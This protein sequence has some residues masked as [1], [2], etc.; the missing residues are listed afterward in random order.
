V[1]IEDNFGHIQHETVTFTIEDAD[2]T[3]IWLEPAEDAFV[4]REF[5]MN[6]VTS[7][8]E[9][10]KELDLNFEWPLLASVAPA[11]AVDFAS[12][13]T[14]SYT[15]NNNRLNVKLQNDIAS[16][17]GKK[18][19][20]TI[21][22][23]IDEKIYVNEIFRVIPGLAVATYGD[24]D[25]EAFNF[26]EEFQREVQQELRFSLV[27]FM[28]GFPGEILVTDL[29]DGSYPEGATVRVGVNTGVTGADG[30]AKGIAVPTGNVD[31]VA[32]KDGK[33]SFTVTT[34]A[35]TPILTSTPTG[36]RSG[37]NVDNNTTKTITWLS[38]P[39][40]LPAVMKIAKE[41]DGEGAFVEH[42]GITKD[43][44]FAVSGNVAKGNRV[45]V[46]GLEPGTTYIYQ[47]GDGETW[48]ATRTFTT[49][50]TTD[51]FSFVGWG[52]YQFTSAD[53]IGMKLAAGNTLA[54]MDQLPFFQLN[55]GDNNDTD[56]SYS[57]FA[58]NTAVYDQRPAI[59]EMNMFAA[60]GNHEYMGYSGNIKFLN[61]HPEPAPSPNYN[62]TWV[63]TGS[64]YGIYG[65]TIALSLDWEG[66]VAR[67]TEIAK[68]MDEVLSNYPDMTWRI[69][70]LH[71][72][73]YPNAWT[74]G[75]RAAFE[76]VFHK[77]NVNVVFCGHGHSFRRQ[78]VSNGSAG[79]EERVNVNWADIT[80]KEGDVLHWELGGLRPSD[81][82]SQKWT[83]AEVDGRKI[84]FIVRNGD[85]SIDNARSFTLYHQDYEE[86][87]INFNTVCNNTNGTKTA[88]VN[89][90]AITDGAIVQ[91]G[92]DVTFTAS[93][94]TGYKVKEWT[95]NGVP[96]A[97]HTDNVLVRS[98]I[99]VDKVVTV[100]FEVDLTVGMDNVFKNMQLFPNPFTHEV[101]ITDAQ[102]STLQVVN[103]LG[104]VMHTQ[105]I[106]SA[107]EI[108][109][110][111]NLAA[112]VYFF[113]IEKDG[114]V[115][116]LKVVK[117]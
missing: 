58:Q 16:A 84:S 83:L 46:T 98:N 108:V 26:F 39:S 48:S 33:Y 60:Y 68:W 22:I 66:S 116:T 36:I 38:A 1:Y 73:L 79:T 115:Q 80:L 113:N 41:T 25:K 67:Q 72:G 104:A 6:V 17:T 47:V 97:G 18:T 62:V 20:A 55:V 86:L 101:R 40:T 8:A 77:H 45:L 81:G 103:I 99:A 82:A 95:V 42:T 109:R 50:W 35:L 11:G 59:G 57:Y 32:T 64:H 15:Y 5:L 69:V 88:T 44:N 94:N 111:E 114:Q 89:D 51:R 71:Y 112:G 37:S 70:T 117:Q 87:T 53:H 54:A 93:P 102:N 52:D 7:K 76:P 110:L 30:I 23:S 100:E 34:R 24:D 74:P 31:I 12:G 13:V 43:L 4:G 65:N 91:K 61:G 105:Q 96:V 107:N 3:N 92:K 14:G 56:D 28:T 49:T 85:N 9:D 75:S 27:R 2:A 90:V 106:A 10:V 21:K 19:L 63:G 29:A 78:L